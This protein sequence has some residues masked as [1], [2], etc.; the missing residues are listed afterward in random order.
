[1]IDIPRPYAKRPVTFFI[2]PKSVPYYISRH[3]LP[4]DWSPGLQES[5]RMADV[6]L[7]TG[8]TLVHYF[9]TGSYE[10]LPSPTTGYYADLKRDVSVYIMAKKYEIEGLQQ[11][12][13][14]SIE[15]N[16][17]QLEYLECLEAIKSDF[18][19]LSSVTSLNVFLS[20]RFESELDYSEAILENEAFKALLDNPD[21]SRFIVRCMKKFYGH[22]IRHLNFLGQ[23]LSKELEDLR[24]ANGSTLAFQ[25]LSHT[26]ADESPLENEKQRF[27]FSQLSRLTREKMSKR[28]LA[29]KIWSQMHPED[30]FEDIEDLAGSDEEMIPEAEFDP[31]SPELVQEAFPD[32]EPDPEVLEFV[33]EAIV[34]A[35]ADKDETTQALADEEEVELS[36]ESI[37]E[38]PEPSPVGEM[39]PSVIQEAP[40]SIDSENSASESVLRLKL[41]HDMQCPNR[42]SHV[43]D[44]NTWKSCRP[45]RV[46]M[47]EVLLETTG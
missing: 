39:M 5:I 41:G 9:Y 7:E 2:G 36:L 32:E 46:F 15:R 10:R 23:G 33:Q 45:C 1:M 40:A 4:P 44:G 27:T 25:N 12:A 42:A 18:N 28:K 20:L 47:Q 43:M 31:D 24:N 30:S 11:L 22:K 14:K 37:P 19:Q 17:W 34:E 8:H 6:D 3:L 13:T 16:G 26:I 21:I 29:R 38:I 35:E